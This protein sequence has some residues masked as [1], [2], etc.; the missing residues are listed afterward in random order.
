M[1]KETKKAFF[2]ELWKLD[3]DSEGS[4]GKTEATLMLERCP[5]PIDKKRGHS[6]TRR[7]HSSHVTYSLPRS[8]SVPTPPSPALAKG[9]V[10]EAVSY[11]RRKPNEDLIGL[12]EHRNAP[13]RL[14]PEHLSRDSL[15]MA[16]KRKRD[17]PVKVLPE[18]KQIFKGL[19]FFFLPN[20]D[21]DPARRMRIRK[22]REWGA[23]WMPEWDDSVTHIIVDRSLTGKDL[24][25]YFEG[26]SLSDD[27]AVVNERYPSDCL[28]YGFLIDANPA[29]HHIPGWREEAPKITLTG[30]ALTGPRSLELKPD[31]WQDQPLRQAPSPAKSKSTVSPFDSNARSEL[32][33]N[34]SPL[35]S[36]SSAPTVSP[37]DELSS[38][39]EEVKA[40]GDLVSGIILL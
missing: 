7:I 13:G 27:A 4:E 28:Q 40:L 37:V 36:T 34:I 3:E 19:R 35:K 23:L 9:L 30:G 32:D 5:P 12:K 8:K 15:R 38:V 10:C 1:E 25:K 22:A 39:I 20:N 18:A 2:Q 16:K 24:E 31:K 17:E 26:K 14:R 29:L 6:K 33:P 21:I 11:S